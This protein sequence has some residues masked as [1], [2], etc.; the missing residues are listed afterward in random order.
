ME[1]CRRRRPE[2]RGRAPQLSIEGPP[3]TLYVGS[4][5]KRHVAASPH[6]G[7]GGRPKSIGHSRSFVL[8]VVALFAVLLSAD[9]ARAECTD[10]AEPGV[11]WRRCILDGINLEDIDLTGSNL[12]D[13]SF[14]RADFTGATLAKS[15]ATRAKFVSASLKNANLDE[16]DFTNADLTYADMSGASLR[17][18]SLRSAKLFRAN[19][20]SA[21]LTGAILDGVDLL[22]ADLSLATWVDGTTICAE[23]SDGRCIPGEKKQS[24][25]AR[26]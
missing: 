10:F 15:N 8:L 1:P 25:H 17:G 7:R 19:L 12:R 20:R 16:A 9:D 21:D 11:E 2:S 6:S 23:G 22:H 4:M 24:A 3:R 13:S 5:K 26:E 18:A 14:K